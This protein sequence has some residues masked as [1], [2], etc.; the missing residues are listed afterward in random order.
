VWVVHVTPEAG[1]TK[2]G[3]ARRVPLHPHL[4]EQGITALAK[5]GDTTPLFYREGAGN[6]VNPAPKIRA[7]DLSDWVRSLGATDPNVQPNHGWRHR[8]KTLSRVVGIPEELADRIQ[9]HAPKH[10]GGKYGTGALPV[11]VL[12]AE[13]ER[14]PRYEV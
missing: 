2:D 14:M 8:F 9:G 10:Q 6:E 11:G 3:K 12:L 13:I 4:I 5:P 7:T 1:S